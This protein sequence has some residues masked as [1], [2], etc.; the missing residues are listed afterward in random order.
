LYNSVW[1]VKLG[2]GTAPNTQNYDTTTGFVG[3]NPRFVNATD[4]DFHLM[5]RAGRWNN[6]TKTWVTDNVTSPCIDAGD[7]ADTF[8]DEPAPNGGRINM[9]VYGSTPLASKSGLRGRYVLY[10]TSAFD[11]G[12]AAANSDDDGAI[13][14]DKAAILPGDESATFANYT[15]Y[16]RGINGIMM[17]IP[18]LPAGTPTAS[19]FIFKVGNPAAAQTILEANFDSNTNGFTYF[20]DTFRGT[21][22]P[23]YISGNRIASGAY[24][25]GGLRVHVYM[26]GDGTKYMSGGW[27]RTFN[28]SSASRVRL[29][30]RY[31]LSQKAACDAGEYSEALVSIDGN[32]VGIGG[33]DYL[34]KLLGSDYNDIGYDTGWQMVVLDLGVLSAGD[35]T[36]IIGAHAKVS[37]YSEEVEMLIDDVSVVAGIADPDNWANAPAPTSISV[38]RGAG[39][40][41]TDRVTILWANNAIQKQWLQVTAKATAATG[42]SG[43]DVFY[44]GNAIGETGNSATDA[45]VK[46]TDEIGARNN[47]HSLGGPE[48]PAGI[49]DVYD[50]D[51]DKKVGPTDEI[52][53]R[54]N[55]TNSSTALKLITVP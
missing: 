1:N 26:D 31:K 43:S 53:A 36:L 47:P 30:L 22:N 13:A 37:N 20:D 35:H 55:G 27:K 49:D 18:N 45:M 41:G 9:G 25:G 32:L 24:S 17:D 15:S 33:N 52:I 28:L 46:P 5:S 2:A 29:T 42:L 12:N 51:R 14:P 16:S 4:K 34:A 50:F 3:A 23:S 48:G 10:N 40:G 8:S 54:N 6:T 7:P 19:D 11:G 44:F 38:R 21:N 39:S